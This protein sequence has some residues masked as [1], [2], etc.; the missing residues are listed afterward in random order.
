M[1]RPTCNI[2]LCLAWPSQGQNL[3]S[4]GK[5]L[6][7]HGHALAGHALH[8]WAEQGWVGLGALHCNCY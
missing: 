1:L 8:G 7:S 5:A 2:K 6:L 4:H 3:Q